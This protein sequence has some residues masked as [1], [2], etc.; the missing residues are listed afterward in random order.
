VK[1]AENCSKGRETK[2][3]VQKDLVLEKD[4]RQS[5]ELFVDRVCRNKDYPYNGQLSP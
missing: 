5:V 2:E 4:F 3:K 1:K